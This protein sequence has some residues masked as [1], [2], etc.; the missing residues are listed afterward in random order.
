MGT[1]G[2]YKH[3]QDH[4]DFSNEK[5]K[6]R[7]QSLVIQQMNS[8]KICI[9]YMQQ[10]G[11]EKKVVFCEVMVWGRTCTKRPQTHICL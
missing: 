11:M 8:T 3:M 9:V 7:Q 10:K 1:S 6:Y 4:L 2:L 5:Y